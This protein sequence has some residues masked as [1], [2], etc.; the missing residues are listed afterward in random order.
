MRGMA[1]VAHRLLE[2]VASQRTDPSR[3]G[4]TMSS[5][6]KQPKG[7]ILVVDDD[8]ES[9]NS[10]AGLLGAEHYVV[11]TA[12][13]GVEA[14]ARVAEAPP[15]VVVT[16]LNMPN[17]GGMELLAAVREKYAGIPVIVITALT[18]TEHA[19]AAM[20]AGAEDYVTKPVDFD[21]LL[22][23]IERAIE[24]SRVRAEADELRRHLSERDAQGIRGMLGVSPAM[25]K[26][27]QLARNVAPS[28]ATVLLTGESG[29]GKSELAR[30]IHS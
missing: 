5:R 7:N 11:A 9:A 30:V 27:Y 10:V 8:V 22:I 14:L 25:Q 26:V 13:D 28:R 16:D 6:D 15:D 21:A 12:S 3:T 29:T 17:M 23:T 19:V 2:G 1:H 24:R 20:R 18:D 4:V